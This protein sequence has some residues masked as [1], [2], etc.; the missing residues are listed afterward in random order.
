G[1]VIPERQ[2]VLGVWDV[3]EK[4]PEPPAPLAARRLNLNDVGA[5]IAQQLAAEMAGFVGQL[6]YAQA[7][8]RARELIGAH[9]SSISSKYGRRGRLTGQNVPSAKPAH[10]SS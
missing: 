1:V 10:I 7:C 3:V 6:Q 4:W 9:H 8:E 5:E 2:A